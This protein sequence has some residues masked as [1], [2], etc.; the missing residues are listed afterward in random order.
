MRSIQLLAVTAAFAI[1]IWGR[2]D[3]HTV[4]NT[5]IHPLPF[6]VEIQDVLAHITRVRGHFRYGYG[7]PTAK[8]GDPIDRTTPSDGYAGAC[9]V[10]RLNKLCRTGDECAPPKDGGGYCLDK[11][12]NSQTG[13][14]VGQCWIRGPND[15]HIAL[16]RGAGLHRE[17][18]PVIASRPLVIGQRY[19]VPR[20]GPLF[21]RGTSDVRL[22]ACVNSP[23]STWE[24]NKLTGE[25]Y[26]DCKLFIEGP[27]THIP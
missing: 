6:T 8:A 10:Q 9:V 15:C 5:T 26:P 23:S 4:A 11:K 12:L 24:V 18:E 27:P 1:G 2:T 22:L 16:Y 13:V 7:Y 14:L 19:D 3:A 25:R 17:G 20:D 21:V